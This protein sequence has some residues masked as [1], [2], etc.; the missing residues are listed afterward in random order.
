[1]TKVL[2]H[3]ATGDHEDED[4]G[5]ESI[6]VSPMHSDVQSIVMTDLSIGPRSKESEALRASALVSQRERST[7]T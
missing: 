6:D 2:A 1:L 7:K 3:L 5:N 4:G